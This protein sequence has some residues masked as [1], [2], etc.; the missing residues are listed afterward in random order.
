MLRISY[1]ESR[2]GS[3]CALISS[4]CCWELIYRDDDVF[5]VSMLFALGGY[6][7]ARDAGRSITSCREDAPLVTLGSGIWDLEQ[8]APSAL[9]QAADHR[10]V[11]V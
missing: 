7:A 5:G 2:R 1:Q 11:R 4:R 8:W 10:G 6:R 3:R 9:L